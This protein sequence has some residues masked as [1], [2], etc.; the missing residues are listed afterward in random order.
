MSVDGPRGVV[1]DL[2]GVVY[3]GT[4]LLPGANQRRLYLRRANRLP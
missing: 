1:L 2:D 4:V 3:R